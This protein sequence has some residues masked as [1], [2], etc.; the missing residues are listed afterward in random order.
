MD[1]YLATILQFSQMHSD[2]RTIKPQHSSALPTRMEE[3]E[4]F[5]GQ[6][7]DE[8][9][10]RSGAEWQTSSSRSNTSRQLLKTASP[11]ISHLVVFSITSALW[12]CALLFIVYHPQQIMSSAF[13]NHHNT[14]ILA[15]ETNYL[16]CG[17]SIPE[18]QAAGCQYD[19]LSNH[20]VPKECV[21]PESIE[22]YQSDE[23]WFGYADENRTELLRIEDMGTRPFYYTSTRDHIVHCAMLWR[24]QYRALSEGRKYLDSIIVDEEHTMHCSQ[25]LI[26]MSE[27]GPDF[28]VMPIKVSAPKHAPTSHF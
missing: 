15:T 11:S 17:R 21:D 1:G 18:A 19:I 20:W 22:E 8:T 24:K 4:P 2:I 7:V 12:A 13:S 28:R 6:S 23:S 16:K 25:Y 9:K 10:R 27:R 14:S 26:E 5:L 3:A